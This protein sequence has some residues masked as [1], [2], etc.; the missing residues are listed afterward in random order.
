MSATP[1]PVNLADVRTTSDLPTALA[2]ALCFAFSGLAALI[3]QTAWTRQFALVFG[4]SELA[5]ATVLAAYM[6]GLALGAWLAERWLPRITRPVLTYAAL[7]LGIGASAVIL[8]PALLSASDGLLRA[9][10]GGQPAPP[11]SAHTAISMFYLASAFVA[12][13]VPTVLMGATLPLL[14]RHAVHTEAQ[15]GRRIGMLYAM[16]TAGAVIG[17]LIT[18]F[19]LLPNAGL[20][21][22]VRVGAAIN[23]VVFLLAASIA[24][25]VPP[26]PLTSPRLGEPQSGARGFLRVPS[27]TW[28]LP[29]LLLS[30]AVSF[31]HEV[32]WTRMLSHVL[33]SSIH[34]FGVMVASF[35]G[36]IAIG[37][38][39]G[40]LLA[41]NRTWSVRALALSQ[42]GCAATAAL[43]YV[44]LNDFIPEK[45]TLLETSLYGVMIL[46]PLTLFVGTTYPLAVRILAERAED[47]A[48]VSARVYAWNT[49]GAIVGSL[50]AGFILIPWLRFEGAVQL[51]V[52][53]SAA[54]GIASLWL[55]EMPPRAIGI[56]V[57]VAT[58]AAV[59]FFRPG[60]PDSLIRSSPLYIQNHG[61]I[62][63][64]DVGRSASVV[65]LKQDGGL[66]L[67][68]NGL[69]EALMEMSG[70]SPRFSGEFWLSP[71]A[72]I[73]R[74][75]VEN[76]LIVGF[77]GGVVIENVPASVRA[78]DVIELEQL[79]IEGNRA[80]RNLRKRDPL[81]DP[82]VTLITNDARGALGLTDKR[83]DAIV[84]QPSH[85]WTAGASHLYTLEFMQQARQHLTDGGVFVQWMNVNFVNEPLLRSLTATLLTAFENVRIYRPDP[86]TLVFLASAAPFNL[87]QRVV[88]TGIPLSYSPRQ[89]SHVG[90]NVAE[91]L[92]AALAVDE[93]GAR[94][95]A[96]GSPLI[97]DDDNRIATSTVFELQQGLSNE[98]MG[99]LL[100]PYD[101]LR[102]PDSF[103]YRELRQKLAFDYVA[104]R[105]ITFLPLDA[106]IPDR[107]AAIARVLGNTPDSYVIRSLAVAASGRTP[108]SRRIAREALSLFPDDDRL[109]YE[110]LRPSLG[111]LADGSAT[112][113]V[114]EEAARFG[115]PAATLI[116][117]RGFAAKAQWAELAGLDRELARM[118]WTDPWKFD[119]VHARVD[120]RGRVSTPSERKRLGE[121]GLALLDAALVINPTLSLYSLRARC[122][123]AAGRTDVLVE[124]LWTFGQATYLNAMREPKERR[125]I[126][127]K[128]LENIVQ[129]LDRE[130][131]NGNG[132]DPARV[133][134]VRTRMVE[135]ISHLAAT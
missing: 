135:A 15:I 54:L 36:G 84:S 47:A 72:V 86:A 82:R 113:E 83:Y 38:A 51:A 55:L 104:R 58:L 93:P 76:M 132:V 95:L 71:L 53:S 28:V 9:A 125:D 29:L 122:A 126:M 34:A 87:E 73:A 90:I 77:G 18:A 7:E 100:A 4:T 52:L 69:P 41:R 49:V 64:Y 3:Y 110:V 119:A 8:V 99:R 124:S 23:F 109:R 131:K 81:A 44:L 107:L 105:H 65:L 96:S 25:R 89:Y 106:S 130:T 37:G 117:A 116:R 5:V 46:L 108:E 80:T 92:V 57:T 42:L 24:K 19:W 129:L 67:R 22:T 63:Y 121:E 70:T 75:S 2:L 91:D 39:I 68:T 120:W 61:E 26:T 85:P 48:R 88:A 45:R 11:D 74:P 17:A 103:V 78:I 14:A 123:I 128:D 60:V 114:L 134:E 98:A 62:A 33:G 133:A 115:E 118:S 112:P 40:A 27:A 79:V 127:R 50:A 35:L 16:N 94:A 21:N 66:A 111:A 31:F 59:A 6:G 10:F 97:T 20:T 30:G 101:P 1:T 32:L 56:G 12:L 43:G 13:A 102:R